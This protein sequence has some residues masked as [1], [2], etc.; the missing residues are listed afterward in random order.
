MVRFLRNTVQLFFRVISMQPRVLKYVLQICF[1]IVVLC[2]AVLEIK[3]V[4]EVNVARVCTT[5][6]REAILKY[7]ASA[8]KNQPKLNAAIHY[9]IQTDTEAIQKLILSLQLLDRNF[10]N[11]FNYPVILF[12]EHNMPTDLYKKLKN[13][14][15]SR[16]VFQSVNF[17]IPYFLE[18]PVPKILYDKPIGYRHMCRFQA[19]GIYEQPIMK[20]LDYAWRLDDD[21]FI[22]SEIPYDIFRYMSDN[23]LMYGYIQ[24]NYESRRR[25]QHLWQFVQ[26]Y[27]QINNIETYN[28]YSWPKRQQFYNNFEVSAMKLWYSKE[29]QD[30]VHIID[31]TGGIYLKMWGDATIKSLGVNM[32]V[33]VTKTHYFCDIG[34]DHET[35]S[36]DSW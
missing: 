21:S 25:S 2:L 34:Y 20:N 13:S 24:I 29:Y 19:M 30:Y 15:K 9:L 17:T 12:H 5:Q 10:N 8:P 28:F 4:I 16:L 18:R 14:T 33:P 27:I 3:N 1:G 26:S 6:E 7:I 11:R 22:Q 31:R 32:F 35:L 36:K 23:D